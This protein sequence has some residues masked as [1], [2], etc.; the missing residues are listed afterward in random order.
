MGHWI[1]SFIVK[2]RSREV[3]K[4]FTEKFIRDVVLPEVEKSGGATVLTSPYGMPPS[5]LVMDQ[6]QPPT[7]VVGM[8]VEPVPLHPDAVHNV[9]HLTM[10][11]NDVYESLAATAWTAV[12]F[13]LDGEGWLYVEPAEVYT[14]HYMA[15]EAGKANHQLAIFALHT[16]ET[17]WLPQETQP[18]VPLADR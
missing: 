12:G 10:V 7:W 4:L 14:N 1:Y 18:L 15:V 6:F 16:G 13:W 2:F 3:I 17:E 11:A 5:L 8:G 9:E